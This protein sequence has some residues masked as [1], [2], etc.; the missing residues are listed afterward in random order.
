ML[1]FGRVWWFVIWGLALTGYG[2]LHR[3]ATERYQ[4]H[5]ISSLYRGF[6]KRAHR[7]YAQWKKV[8]D[9]GAQNLEPL[10]V[11]VPNNFICP[12]KKLHY[13]TYYQSS[14]YQIVR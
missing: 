12:P 5:S 4:F 2:V 3:D 11:Q 7:R 10:S 9:L 14:K 1:R 13:H 8:R 6:S